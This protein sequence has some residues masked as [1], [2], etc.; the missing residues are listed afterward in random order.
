MGWLMT[1]GQSR[2]QLIERRIASFDDGNGRK[3]VCLKHAL[4]GTCLWKVMESTYPDGRVERWIGLDRLGADRGL[5]WGYRHS[6]LK[7]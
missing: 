6:W 3:D 1:Q 4:A 7:P 5:G 2:K